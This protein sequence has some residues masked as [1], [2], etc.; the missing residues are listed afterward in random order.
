MIQEQ[1]FISNL[2]GRNTYKGIKEHALP[3]VAAGTNILVV[4]YILS[5]FFHASIIS[6]LVEL[7]NGF[8][9]LFLAY[10]SALIILLDYQVEI[11][12]PEE[13][14]WKKTPKEPKPFKYKLTIA[15]GVVLI[16]LGIIAIIYSNKYR[17]QYAFE[18]ET[19]LVDENAGL[20]HLNM[21]IDCPS[22]D[23]ADYL[24][25]MKG[26]QIDKSYKFCEDCEIVVEEGES[27]SYT[28]HARP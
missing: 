24:E 21:D 4:L 8:S 25:E 13:S 22:A 28:T 5:F 14:P 1:S 10:I 15:W 23:A 16:A 18:C 2:I 9:L 11:D 17:K 3:I 26:Y 27:E 7:F 6:Y 19:F 12:E 20:F